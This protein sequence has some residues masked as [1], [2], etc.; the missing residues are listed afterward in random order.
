MT[1]QGAGLN[2]T[3]R[4]IGTGRFRLC[5]VAGAGSE[6]SARGPFQYLE[7]YSCAL[8]VPLGNSVRAHPLATPEPD[9]GALRTERRRWRT[10]PAEG[11]G[12]D[13]TS[14]CCWN[15]VVH[16]VGTGAEEVQVSC[17]SRHVATDDQRS[18]TGEREIFGFYEPSNDSGHSELKITQHSA[19]APSWRRN[20]S[21]HV[22]RT[23]GGS[24]SSSRSSASSLG[25][26]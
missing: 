4:L 25:S 26:T 20:H 1:W 5:P 23:V 19:R 16:R 14:R 15:Q 3:Q 8:L 6:L 21:S 10:R 12:S 24:T 7:P 13:P 11:V 18:T 22:R 9:A 2:R 17:G